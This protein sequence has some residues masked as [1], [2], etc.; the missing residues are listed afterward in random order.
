MTM[1]EADRRVLARLKR[2]GC[3]E[4]ELLRA[5]RQPPDEPSQ[6]DKCRIVAER[7]PGAQLACAAALV[8]P[9]TH[10]LKRLFLRGG[11]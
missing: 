3:S 7:L 5:Y 6:E 2:S 11:S 8:M 9:D 4:A 10:P 1:S